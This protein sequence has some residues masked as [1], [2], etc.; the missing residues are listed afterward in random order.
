MIIK[1]GYWMKIIATMFIIVFVFTINACDIIDDNSLSNENTKSKVKI[2]LDWYPNANHIG[3]FIAKNKGYFEEEGLDVTLYTPSDPSTVLQTVGSGSDDFG[4]SYQPDVLLARAQDV[5]VVSVLG[6]VQHPLNSIM[7]L[8]TS[9]IVTPKDLVGKKVGYPG[10]PTD[11]PLLETM[12]R[13]EGSNGLKDVELVNVGFNLSESLISGKVDAIIGAYW[14]HESILMENKGYPVNIMKVQEWGVPDYYELV[15]VTNEDKIN[16]NSRLVS[17][18]TNALV[19]GFEDAIN[20]PQLGVDI[21]V[22][23]SNEEIDESIDRPGADL[24]VE[25][26]QDSSG[27]FGVQKLDKWQSFSNWMFN[28]GLLTKQIVAEDAFTNK[29]I[30]NNN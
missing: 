13:S 10:I 15:L 2:A 17:S 30:K 5:P 29:F 16:N 26:W 6:I 3:F 8:K 24:L 20:E 27:D 23:E 4:V 7:S 1:K 12:L 22:K 25:E 19:K 11:E 14:T 18:L 28:K 21:L 9:N